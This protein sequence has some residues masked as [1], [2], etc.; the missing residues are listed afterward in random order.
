MAAGFK[1][2]KGKNGDGLQAAWPA[3][4][5]KMAGRA[6]KHGALGAEWSRHGPIRFYI[7]I[8]PPPAGRALRLS[9]RSPGHWPS[10]RQGGPKAQ[11]RHLLESLLRAARCGACRAGE[12]DHLR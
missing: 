6:A 12:R 3:P 7:G 4:A 11:W 9:P 5:A 2:K 10:R 1:D 8:D